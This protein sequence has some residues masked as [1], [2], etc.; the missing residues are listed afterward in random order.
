MPPSLCMACRDSFPILCHISPPFVRSDAVWGSPKFL[1]Y[2]FTIMPWPQTPEELPDTEK[3]PSSS[4]PGV[5]LSPSMKRVSLS[6]HIIFQGSIPSRIVHYGLI[7]PNTSRFIRSV[8]IAYGEFCTP[9]PVRALRRVDFNH[10]CLSSF[11][12]RTH[13]YTFNR[14]LEDC[15]G[16]NNK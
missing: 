5:L 7:S 3:K 14:Y 1:T 16:L 8:T 10:L 6:D 11:P 15:E 12:W 9:L 2:P 13:R 4:Y